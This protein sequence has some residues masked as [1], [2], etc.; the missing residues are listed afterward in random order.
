MSNIFK[1]FKLSSASVNNRTSVYVLTVL[2]FIIGLM[3]YKS[4]PKERLAQ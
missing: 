4:M 1:E 2:I 3:A